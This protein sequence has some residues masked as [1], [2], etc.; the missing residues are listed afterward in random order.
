MKL[1]ITVALAAVLA[2]AFTA[3]AQYKP[4]ADGITASPRVHKMLAEHCACAPSE[5]LATADLAH[6][7]PDGL[8]ASPKVRSLVAQHP[9]TAVGAPASEFSTTRPASDGLAASPK[10]RELLRGWT[11]R[12]AVEL[13]PISR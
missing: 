8:A 11:V 13:A 2:P 10:V 3:M 4:T 6:P 1:A 5:P 9:A 7:Q 12:T